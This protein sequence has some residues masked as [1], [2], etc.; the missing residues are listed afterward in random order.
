M[1]KARMIMLS[2]LGLLFG[3]I[4]LLI[5]LLLDVLRLNLSPTAS[6][7]ISLLL[8]SA[9]VIYILHLA[10]KKQKIT[11]GLAIIIALLST[12]SVFAVLDMVSVGPRGETRSLVY[13]ATHVDCEGCEWAKGEWDFYMPDCYT[14]LYVRKLEGHSLKIAAFDYGYTGNPFHY[15]P[16][17]IEKL[18]CG[19][20]DSGSAFEEYEELLSMN[21][22]NVSVSD[23]CFTAKNDTICVYGKLD[24]DFILVAKVSRNETHLLAFVDGWVGCGGR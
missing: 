18:L 6:I 1:G 11:V 12:Y 2:A 13:L 17:L 8:T 7:T 10:A 24:G 22:F 4:F 20:A 19:Y 14:N 5:L 16:V 23:G 3:P 9:I 21:G 15:L